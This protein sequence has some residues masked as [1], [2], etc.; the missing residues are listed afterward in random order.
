MEY[1]I[2]LRGGTVVDPT[3]GL[4]GPMDIGID[5]G[6]VARLAPRI[7]KGKAEMVIDL[8]GKVA[9][10]GILDSHA[11]FSGGVEKVGHR[12]L[13]RA[14]VTCA[15][16]FSATS[17]EL[18]Q[19]LALGGAGLGVGCLSPLI[20]GETVE[21]QDPPPNRLR[22]AIAHA[23]EAGALGVKLLGGH[24][25]LTPQATRMAIEIANDIKAYVASHLGTTATGSH[26]EGMRE[27]PQLL[28]GGLHLHVAHVNSYCRGL[29][30]P[31]FEEARE[32]LDILKGLRGQVVSESYL[33]TINGTSGRCQDDT[34][35]SKVTC[36]CLSLLG[37]PATREGLEEALREGR[38]A[39]VVPEG[40]DM[41]L[42]WGE[43]AAAMWRRAGTDVPLSF[44]VNHP[45]V[46]A[47]LATA[48]DE[49]GRFIVDAISSDGGAYPR[50]L[51]VERGLA[52]VRCGALTL[53]ELVI[54][55]STNPARMF[56]LE[57]KGHLREGADA[58]V[59]VLDLERGRPYMGMARGRIIMVDGKVVGKGGYILTTRACRKTPKGV[60][61]EY[62][63]LENYGLY[64][65]LM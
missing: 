12:M 61:A 48:K 43:E 55:A 57:G 39:V 21:G 31:P 4:H 29:I 64:R 53:E 6:Q 3:Q 51:I 47:L 5:H 32:A 46:N 37:Y 9:I 58:D 62:I 16:D 1:E 28:D 13:A 14:G 35:V 15:I 52:L 30:A 56:G 60:E 8:A 10:P 45:L 18:L 38:A 2:L 49:D 36:N 7:P 44:N 65:G 34:P 50:N 11:H 19:G 23:L 42:V 24:R 26:L 33:G 54:K 25:P 22:Q 40:D 17:D 63:D 41:T 20:P 59:T 27:L